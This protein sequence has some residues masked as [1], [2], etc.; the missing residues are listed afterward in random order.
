MTSVPFRRSDEAWAAM[1]PH[2]PDDQP[3]ARRI[4]GRRVVP[5]GWQIRDRGP[6][7]RP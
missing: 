2:L 3:G 1:Q 7:A 5:K 6:A 4:G